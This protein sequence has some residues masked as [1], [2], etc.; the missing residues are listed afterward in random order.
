MKTGNQICRWLPPILIN[1]TEVD[2][3]SAKVRDVQ[4]S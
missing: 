3:L 1:V 4:G 2:D